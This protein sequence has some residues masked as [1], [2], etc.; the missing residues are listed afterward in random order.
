M[1]Y[2][3]LIVLGAGATAA[4][5]DTFPVGRDFFS[6]NRTWSSSITDYPHLAAARRKVESLK[7]TR[8]DTTPVSLTDAWLFLDTMFKYQC[9]TRRR[10]AYDSRIL[11]IRYAKV[12]LPDYLKA[13]YLNGSY[14]EVCS[15]MHP[16]FSTLPKRI[17]DMCDQ[18]DPVG[19]FLLIAGWELKHLLYK[20]YNPQ[21]QHG[22]LCSQLSK[23]VKGLLGNVAVISFNY[24]I[25][26]EMS[27]RE[28]GVPLELLPDV[29]SVP[30]QA[31]IPF[32][33]PHGGWNIRHLNQ[34]I[35]PHRS[36]ADFVE[37]QYF[38]KLPSLEERPAM[39]PYFSHPDEISELHESRYPDVGKFFLKQQERMQTLLKNARTI[40]S[41]G[42]SFS[43]IHVKE[44]VQG[45]SSD[46]NG[47]GKSM[48]CVLKGDSERQHIMSLWKFEKED[49]R[50]FK[51]CPSGFDDTSIGEIARFLG[52]GNSQ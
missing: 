43:D 16:Y 19:Y 39:I 50:T 51:Y 8:E 32:C 27:C 4:L 35:E 11:R 38:D 17:Y 2:E 36:L 49:G 33:K 6:S 5:G 12:N 13:D 46:R 48:L 52:A 14:E 31:A 1:K 10:S 24:D 45:I 22:N 44:I 25:Y 40:A 18:S 34:R 20:T 41:I 28:Q 26:F 21:I 37:D 29:E 42:Y 47:R 7:G 30:G 3:Y 15:D 23:A 9:A